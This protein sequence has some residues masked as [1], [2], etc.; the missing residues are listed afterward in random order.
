MYG[1]Y[2]QRYDAD[3]LPL[4]VIIDKL[5]V[6]DGLP[7]A[8]SNLNY[9]FDGLTS[10]NYS[11]TT[12][13]FSRYSEANA[14]DIFTATGNLLDVV[15]NGVLV[16]SGAVIGVVTQNAGG[17]LSLKFNSNATE[18][19]VN[20]VIG[21]IEY[22]NNSHT[23]PESVRIDWTFDNNDSTN[24]AAISGI[25]PIN[26]TAVNDN[27]TGSCTGNAFNCTLSIRIACIN[28]NHLSNLSF[29]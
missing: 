16:L 20:E 6:E 4:G 5:Y 26:I 28:R 29:G 8:L 22:A 24:P 3:G 25:I 19:K 11:N 12:L 10:G 1:I 14:E 18:D 15:E 23:P 17:A 27:P 21:S 7:I 9:D 2:A 13:T